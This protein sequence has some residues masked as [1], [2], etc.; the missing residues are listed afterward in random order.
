M[1]CQEIVLSGTYSPAFLVTCDAELAPYTNKIYLFS[2]LFFH[3][4]ILQGSRG[5]RR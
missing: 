4:I 3:I 1:S 2:A 5:D